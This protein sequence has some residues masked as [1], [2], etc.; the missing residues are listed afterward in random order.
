MRSPKRQKVTDQD[1]DLLKYFLLEATEQLAGFSPSLKEFAQSLA[2]QLSQ[3]YP[4]VRFALLSVA[5]RTQ[6]AAFR[7]DKRR[8]RTEA[9]EYKSSAL[10]Y[11]NQAIQHLTNPAKTKLPPEVYLVCGLLFAATESWPHVHMAPAVHVLTAFRLILWGT[12]T[13][14]DS[15]KDSLFPFLL[16]M[17]RK[18]LAFS[19]DDI[20]SDLSAAMRYYLWTHQKPDPIPPTFTSTNQAWAAIETL[21]YYVSVLTYPDPHFNELAR[22][23]ALTYS[24]ALSTALHRTNLE[25]PLDSHL[26]HQYRTLLLHHRTLDLMLNTTLH[27]SEQLYDLFT[28]DFTHILSEC[29]ALLA[30]R[31]H[32]TSTNNIP[33]P[34]HQP[35][36]PTLGL[37]P[38]LFFTATRCRVSTLRHRAIRALHA[39]RRREREWNSC[40]ATL[41]ARVVVAEEER[42]I[43]L[44]SP[45]TSEVG[46][47]VTIQ[48]RVRIE[49]VK[50]DREEER[51]VVKLVNGSNGEVVEREV[52]WRVGEGG[53][54]D[55][56]ECVMLSRGRL[57][58]SGYSGIMLVSPGIACQCGVVG[59]GGSD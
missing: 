2:P 22:P 4:A 24:T 23:D 26:R 40:I 15:V 10:V 41:L 56:F 52:G 11:Y 50:F 29:E 14:P 6:A 37:L 12:S 7:W 9:I 32:P 39:S 51:M 36:H 30:L 18:T 42:H 20:P 28:D 54:D 48:H 59:G 8:Q 57:R 46:E 38:P 34:Q 5:A 53:L 27:P 58:V 33:S 19:D 43:A 17:G 16:H 3:Q 44:S 31:S 45:K 49:E 21:Q 13:L 55:D 47:V 25:L 35:W 1:D